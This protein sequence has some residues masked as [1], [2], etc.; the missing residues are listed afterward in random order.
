[1]VVLPKNEKEILN[2]CHWLDII[3]VQPVTHSCF[4]R[5]ELSEHKEFVFWF[6]EEK[7]MIMTSKE[8]PFPEGEEFVTVERFKSIL[9][10]NKQKYSNLIFSI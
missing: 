3:Q 7:Q 2:F 1:M 10:K 6:F 4:K 9:K 5:F 8:F